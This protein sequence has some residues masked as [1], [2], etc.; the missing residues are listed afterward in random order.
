MDQE[1]F[2]Y[3]D[4]MK[5]GSHSQNR[6]KLDPKKEKFEGIGEFQSDLIV[7]ENPSEMNLTIKYQSIL[8][9]QVIR[10]KFQIMLKK[11]ES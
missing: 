4:V 7:Q 9:V 11:V 3:A 6:R 1:G 10:W 8:E 2:I 5:D